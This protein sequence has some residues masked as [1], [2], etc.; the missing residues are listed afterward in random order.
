[1]GQDEG[2]Y[3]PGSDIEESDDEKIDDLGSLSGGAY[4]TSEGTFRSPW[5][6]QVMHFSISR[7]QNSKQNHLNLPMGRGDFIYESLLV[8]WLR[9]WQNQ[10]RH[11]KKINL[12]TGSSSSLK[13]SFLLPSFS[14]N[15]QVHDSTLKF[16]DHLDILMPLCLK[17]IILRYSSK[18]QDTKSRTNRVIVDQGHMNVLESFVE[19]FALSLMGKAVQGIRSKNDESLKVSLNLSDHVLDFFV[20]LCAVLH[21]AQMDVLIRRY[22]KALRQCEPDLEDHTMFKWSNESLYFTKCSRQLRLRAVER[23]A[24]LP[25]FVALNY[26]C[27]VL[28][29]NNSNIRQKATWT[30]QYKNA[31]DQ[32]YPI[33]DK[34]RIGGDDLLP[35]SGW[36]AEL[37]T[38]E[39]LS[40][41]A[42]SC[43]AVVA[44]AMAHME[45]KESDKEPTATLDRSDLLMFQSIAIHAITTVHELLLRHHAMDRRFQRESSRGR[46][47]AL[48]AR[49]I[50]DQSLA[51]VRWLARLESTHKVR[52]LW[53][54]CFI[55]VLQETPENLLRQAVR[56]YSSPMVSRLF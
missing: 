34:L 18:V 31:T 21:P 42:L 9:V 30:S 2:L 14:G 15:S 20:G 56:S 29:S 11:T 37:L 13:Y 43:E 40:I 51:S 35:K 33:S 45:S 10:D 28:G 26:P 32:G 16:F 8:I 48:F 53:L 23:L 12:Q 39:S 25:N 46:V 22:F 3:S 50:F 19:M 4:Y 17:S 47:A 54:L 24:I 36:L 55:Y 5:N 27:R 44:E 38:N 6:C 49:P 7:D 52:S 1:M 41:C